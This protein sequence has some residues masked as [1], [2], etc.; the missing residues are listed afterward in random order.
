MKRVKIFHYNTPIDLLERLNNQFRHLESDTADPDRVMDFCLTAWSM[1]DWVYHHNYYDD[2]RLAKEKFRDI[3]IFNRCEELKTMH[4]IANGIKHLVFMT[5]D[6]NLV[7][8]VFGLQLKT[9]CL[10]LSIVPSTNPRYA[11]TL[12]MKLLFHFLM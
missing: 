7:L 6:R 12:M 10:R 9:N 11:W 8:M 1:A 3:H 4:D 2:S 5:E